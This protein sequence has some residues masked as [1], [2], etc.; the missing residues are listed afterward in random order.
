MSL[1]DK[2]PVKKVQNKGLEA[3]GAAKTL[4]DNCLRGTAGTEAILSAR[5]YLSRAEAEMMRL[6]KI[7]PVRTRQGTNIEYALENIDG[8]LLLTE[9]RTGSTSKPYRTSKDLYDSLASALHRSETPPDFEQLVDALSKSFHAEVPLH[10]V[11]MVLRFWQHAP[12]GILKR[13]KR[14]YYQIPGDFLNAS[15]SMW[16]KLQPD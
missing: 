7:R 14:K 8:H 15:Q 1:P 5:R 11:R 10:E 16:A 13:E 4:L 9:K 12:L 3:L 2:S 6:L